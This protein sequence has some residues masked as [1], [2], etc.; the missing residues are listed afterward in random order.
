MARLRVILP[1]PGVTVDPRHPGDVFMGFLFVCLFVVVFESG[2]HYAARDD[3]EL[4]G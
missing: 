4:T 1:T 3:P 2:S